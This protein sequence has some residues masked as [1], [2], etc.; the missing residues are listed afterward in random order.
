MYAYK[1][2]KLEPEKSFLPYNVCFPVTGVLTASYFPDP[3]W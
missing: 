3:E 2:D 1:F